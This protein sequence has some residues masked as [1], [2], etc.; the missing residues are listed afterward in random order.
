MSTEAPPADRLKHCRRRS[1]T[2]SCCRRTL[3][4]QFERVASLRHGSKS[5]LVEEALRP[6]PQPGA[7]TR[8]IDDALLR[9]LDE[10]TRSRRPRSSA[11]SPSPPRRCRCSCATSS[12]SRRRCRE[13]EQEPARALG[14]ER[15]EVFVAQVGRRLAPI[16]GSCPRC[17]RSI[18]VAQPG[19][20][21][22]RIGDDAPLEGRPP[23]PGN[24]AR[25]SQANGQSDRRRDGEARCHG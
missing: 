24:A 12:P 20:V 9:R 17:W 1:A 14:K 7:S 16:T 3:A 11:T 8:C 6:P 10:L 5:A 23:S 19:S 25:Q 4:E 15:F 13:G 2:R 22:H 18:A 21:R